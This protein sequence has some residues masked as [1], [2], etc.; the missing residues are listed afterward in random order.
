[1]RAVNKANILSRSE[2]QAMKGL[3]ILSIVMH[4]LCHVMPLARG[5]NEFFYRQ[6]YTDN[7]WNYLQDMDSNWFMVL[8]SFFGQFGVQ[9]FLFLSAYGLV[10]KY[11]QGQSKGPGR[12][13]FISHHYLKLFRLMIIGLVIAVFIGEMLKQHQGGPT[14]IAL[15]LGGFKMHFMSRP[16]YWF[17]QV[18]MITN[19]LPFPDINVYPGPFWFLGLMVEVYVI[20][21]LFLYAPAQSAAWRRWIPPV[22]FVLITW[23]PQLVWGPVGDI[24]TYLRYNFLIA[25]VPFSAGLLTARFIK[26]PRLG[27][28]SLFLLFIVAVAAFVATQYNYYLWLWCSLFFIAA[29]AII[30]RLCG[31]KL[32]K[33]LVWMGTISSAL[34]IVHPIVRIFFFTWDWWP[35]TSDHLY[36]VLLAYT[37]LSI[38]AALGYRK[39]LN[40]LPSPKQV[41]QYR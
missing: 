24:I 18:F 34:F 33:P 1:M 4:N 29:T 27:K 37:A 5:S 32:M 19:I 10:L 3:A 20:Y 35:A 40:L 14:L 26:I 30:V 16:E 28:P 9:V 11:E 23:I 25:G 6:R 39:L 31:E 36:T 12:W 2:C 13:E 41:T 21:R 8:G 22:V 38:L 15:G 17:P 7:L